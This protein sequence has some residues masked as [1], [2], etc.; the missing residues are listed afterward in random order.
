MLQPGILALLLGSG[1]GAVLLA[2]AVVPAVRIIRH[3]DLASGSEEQ[4]RLERQTYLVAAIMRLVMGVGTPRRG[5]ACGARGWRG[6]GG[7]GIAALRPEACGGGRPRSVGP[8]PRAARCRPGV[9]AP[10]LCPGNP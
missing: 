5:E 6:P 3:W 1:L 10:G 9:G 4:L 8:A 7:D 2:A